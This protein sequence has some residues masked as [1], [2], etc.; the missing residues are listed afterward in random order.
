MGKHVPSLR[1]LSIIAILDEALADYIEE[2][3]VPWLSK[4]ARVLF[5]RINVI[6][7]I[8]MA[9]HAGVLQRIRERRNMITHEPAS[10]LIQPVTWGELEDTISHVLHSL[11]A[12]GLIGNAPQITA[13]HEMTAEL[14]PNELGPNEKRIRYK[15]RIWVE[16]ND[17]VLMEFSHEVSCSP[18]VQP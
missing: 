12:R 9:I 6:S 4:T 1:Y 15:H 18:P 17:E 10:I 11:Q 5:N 14:F 8:V 7:D 13:F 2:N 16:H 3:S